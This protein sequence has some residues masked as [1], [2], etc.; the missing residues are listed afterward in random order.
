MREFL[1]CRSKNSESVREGK[2]DNRIIVIRADGFLACR[3]CRLRYC[4]HSEQKEML[5]TMD[6]LRNNPKAEYNWQYTEK[7]E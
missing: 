1:S 7:T 4:R 2:K 5:S 3:L 6:G